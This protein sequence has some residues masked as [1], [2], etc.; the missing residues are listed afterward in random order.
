MKSML[1]RLKYIEK[2]R[3]IEEIKDRER[4]DG[5]PENM[6]VVLLKEVRYVSS[7]L[8]QKVLILKVREARKNMA[9]GYQ[10]N[11]HKSF[12]DSSSSMTVGTETGTFALI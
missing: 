12:F 3:Q 2:E 1:P 7:Q 5:P 4:K 10:C 8:Q 11:H 6:T 9:D